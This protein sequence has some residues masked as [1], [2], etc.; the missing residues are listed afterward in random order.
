MSPRPAA[1][2]NASQTRVEHHVAIGMRD[3]AGVCGTR[4]ATEHHEL[5]WPEGMHVEA[6]TYSHGVLVSR[7]GP[8]W[9]V[10]CGVAA[11]EQRFDD[12]RDHRPW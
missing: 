3:D 7:F 10:T 4:N 9:A 1:P 12:A 6:L 8:G 5:A 11:R 2:S